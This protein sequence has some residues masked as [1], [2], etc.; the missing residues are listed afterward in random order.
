[1]NRLKGGMKL[2]KDLNNLEDGKYVIPVEAIKK[3][4]DEPSAMAPFLDKNSLIT[5]QSNFLF[6]ALIIREEHVITGL[7]LKS[8]AG[9]W[10]E[11]K[12][13]QTDQESNIRYEVFD[14]G[15]LH[16]VIEARVQYEVEQNGQTFSG[17]EKLRL[18][19]DTTELRDVDSIDWNKLS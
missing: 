18:K 10:V 14:I 5:K 12:E 7:Q 4:N 3:D 8:E 9:T 17:D 16:D 15:T 1:M 19:L 6:I 13:K 11:A 2:T